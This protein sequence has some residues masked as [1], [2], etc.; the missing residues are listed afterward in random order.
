MV[1]RDSQ[2][3]VAAIIRHSDEKSKVDT[4]VKAEV[5]THVKASARLT[6]EVAEFDQ[7]LAELLVRPDENL[8]PALTMVSNTL[9]GCKQFIRFCP[10]CVSDLKQIVDHSNLLPLITIG[11]QSV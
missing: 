2:L 3:C 6:P 10:D 11:I 4:L 9:I 7:V 1:V 8:C 5:V